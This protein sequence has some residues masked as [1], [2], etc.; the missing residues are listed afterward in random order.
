MKMSR[1]PG[2]VQEEPRVLRTNK[3]AGQ[4][5]V[6]GS[7]RGL[8]L[9]PPGMFHSSASLEES[10][11]RELNLFNFLEVRSIPMIT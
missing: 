10:I 1:E 11:D 9:L 6:H 4:Q 3:L 5:L 7:G 2:R 8:P